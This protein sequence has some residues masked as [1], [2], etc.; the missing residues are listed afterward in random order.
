MR[1]E[2]QEVSEKQKN[3]GAGRVTRGGRVMKKKKAFFISV[4]GL[5][6]SGKSSVIIFLKELLEKQGRQVKVFREPG[7]TIIGEQIRNVLLDRKNS[8][9]SK[10]TEL[11]LYLAART[12]LIEEK[13]AAAFKSFDVVICDRFF[14]STLAYQGYAMGLG[15]ICEKS[16]KMFSL[17]VTPDLTLLL[18]M[19]VEEGLN[20]IPEK[21]RVESRPIEFHQK[22]RKGFQLL[23]RKNN[24][25][26]KIIDARGTLKD[27]FERVEKVI[28]ERL[29]ASK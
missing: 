17:G 19:P 27:I 2:I 1:F 21:D 25:R 16:V 4:E 12:Q 10:H 23:A 26:I 7:S 11:L 9:L 28:K 22:L 6:G 24:R 15:S 3:R 13:L 14:D 29:P 8:E 18:D 5:E 20:R